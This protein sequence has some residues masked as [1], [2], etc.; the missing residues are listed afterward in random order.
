MTLRYVRSISS[1][2]GR[3]GFA[4]T[5]LAAVAACGA[6]ETNVQPRAPAVVTVDQLDGAPFTLLPPQPILVV[7]IDARAAFDSP[8]YGADL[9][10]L[11]NKLLPLAADAGF[12]PTRDVDRIVI[13]SYSFQGSDVVAILRGRFDAAEI[14]RAAGSALTSTPYADRQMYTTSTF[15]FTILTPHTVLVGT[16]AGLRHALDRIHDVRV[17]LDL[18]PWMME[19]LETKDAAFAFGADFAGAPLS[20]GL[21]G[22]PV[23]PWLG[24][25]KTAR[26]AGNFHEPGVNVAGTVT[27]DDPTHATSGASGMRQLG[28]LVNAAAL[29]GV[30]PQLQDLTI[31]ADGSDVEAKFSIDAA[32][33]HTLLKQFPQYL[34]H[35]R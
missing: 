30:A 22:L 14:V 16:P 10:A 34:A 17:K 32:A 4:L 33:F 1:S 23:P 2:I 21:Q 35:G 9:A 11:A 13:G 27:F 15:G 18:P 3:R 6:S 25:V 7:T 19:T 28:S 8:S 5:V 12:A 26:G 24:S 29:A 20:V 31:S